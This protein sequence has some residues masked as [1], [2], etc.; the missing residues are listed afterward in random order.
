MPT[1]S[2]TVS[3]I[4]QSG[5]L[6]C[7]RHKHLLV[8]LLAASL[9]LAV[10]RGTSPGSSCPSRCMH[11]GRCRHTPLLCWNRCPSANSS[12]P[13]ACIDTSDA[14]Q[15]QSAAASHSAIAHTIAPLLPQ[16]T[17]V[18]VTVTFLMQPPGMMLLLPCLLGTSYKQN[19]QVILH[20]HP[21]RMIQL[22]TSNISLVLQWWQHKGGMPGQL[23]P[24]LLGR[25]WR[26]MAPCTM[27]PPGVALLTGV[28]MPMLAPQSP[29]GLTRGREL[30]V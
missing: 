19:R 16:T 7:S 2:R 13:A 11:T 12:S 25:C 20:I 27:L 8:Q 17:C 9:G 10:G 28:H 5:M 22:G 18:T 29:P 1:K 14:Q 21:I 26:D 23:L 3:S 15:T 24:L 4:A 30:H 6:Q